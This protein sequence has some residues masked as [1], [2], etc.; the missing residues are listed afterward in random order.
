MLVGFLL[1]FRSDAVDG[2]GHGDWDSE[3]RD[4]CEGSILEESWEVGVTKPCHLRV[5]IEEQLYHEF[6]TLYCWKFMMLH[7]FDSKGSPADSL[8]GVT[9][10]T[11]WALLLG[12]AAVSAFGDLHCRLVVWRPLPS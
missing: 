6:L 5:R 10:N 8:D 3:G 9:W 2:V 4:W 7:A 11:V 1:T 12:F